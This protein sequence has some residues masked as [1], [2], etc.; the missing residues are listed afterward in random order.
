MHMRFNDRTDVEGKKT[1]FIEEFQSDWHQQGSE[2]GY[3]SKTV[4]YKA[5]ELND[6]SERE[7]DWSYVD[8]GREFTVGKGVVP[9]R[10]EAVDYLKNYI[11]KSIKRPR[12]KRD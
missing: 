7:Y 9:G 3:Q 11:E 10:Q 8:Q 5:P 12:R 1:L 4:E 6:V 2:K